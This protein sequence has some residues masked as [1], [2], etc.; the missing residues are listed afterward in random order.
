MGLVL[1][2]PARIGSKDRLP[3]YELSVEDMVGRNI[4]MM[5]RQGLVTYVD[6]PARRGPGRPRKV[7]SDDE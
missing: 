7:E 5:E 2:R 6:E 4:A 1:R 3:G